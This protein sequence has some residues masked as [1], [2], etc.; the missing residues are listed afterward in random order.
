MTQIEI[1]GVFGVTL[2]YNLYV[3]DVYG[4]QCV[5]LATVNVSVPPAISM[6]LPTQF[7]SAPSVGVKI[8]DFLGC[9]KFGIIYC[10][11]I[12]SL[13][14]YQNGESFIFMDAN[15]YTYRLI[16]CRIIKD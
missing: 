11:L 7:D 9:E 15:I 5:L 2:P 14:D 6:L 13:S 16:R 10:G 3:C 12:T 1:T 8:I 4:N